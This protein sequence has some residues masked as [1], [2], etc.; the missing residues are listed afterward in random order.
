MKFL[1]VLSA[2]CV[3]INALSDHE[4]WT[5]F[6]LTHKKGYQNKVEEQLRF[7]IFQDNLRR[8]EEHNTKYDN[9]EV[10]YFFTVNQFAD[11]SGEEF[12]ARI[13][14]QI[15]TKPT[16]N[17][18]L[19]DHTQ[20]QVDEAKDWRDV[21]D[22]VVKDQGQC[23]SCWAFSATG[24]TEAQLSINKNSKILLSEQELVDCSTENA[25]CRGGDMELAFEYIKQ[26]GL[27]SEDDYKYTAIHET[28]KKATKVLSTI[29]DFKSLNVGEDVLKTAVG[30]VGPVSIGLNADDNWQLYGGGI[31]DNHLCNGNV[32]NHGVLAVGYGE[33]NNKDFWIIKNSWGTSWGEQGYI[34]LVRGKNQCGVS[35]DAS[36]PVL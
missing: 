10:S 5:E 9:G 25:G 20:Y 28:C 27:S 17:T 26:N 7:Q 36:Y 31:F 30:T 29:S 23:G 8:I 33:A 6:K 24:A 14:K 32:I 19:F 16:L 35:Y 13:N 1:V 11:L 3:A 12:L 15:A 22:L 4:E 18:T 34:R 21:A 2:F